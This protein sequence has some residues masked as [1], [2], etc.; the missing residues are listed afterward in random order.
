MLCEFYEKQEIVQ[1]VW[2]FDLGELILL[3]IFS[4]ICIISMQIVRSRRDQIGDFSITVIIPFI[5][6]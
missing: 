4:G 3:L 6:I 5:P 2:K 1:A